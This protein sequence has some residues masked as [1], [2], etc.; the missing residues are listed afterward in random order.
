MN[1]FLIELKQFFL[2]KK[3]LTIL[4]AVCLVAGFLGLSE[5]NQRPIERIDVS[6]MMARYESRQYF[7]DHFENTPGTDGGELM[8]YDWFTQWNPVEKERIEAAKNHDWQQY[9]AASAQWYR[10]GLQYTGG[11]MVPMP[12]EYYTFGNLYPAYDF[13]YHYSYTE[14][15]LTAFAKEQPTKAALEEK[16][17]LQ[18]FLKVMNGWLPFFLI[19]ATTFSLTDLLLKDRHHRSLVAGYP[20]SVTRILLAKTAVALCGAVTVFGL[21][22]LTIVG[23]NLDQ[24]I[25]SLAYP[26]PVLRLT[27]DVTRPIVGFENFDIRSIGNLLGQEFLLYMLI[28]LVIIRLSWLVALWWK[29]EGLILLLTAGAILAGPL[30]ERRW[31]SI[32]IDRSNDPTLYFGLGQIVTGYRRFFYG[33]ANFTFFKG[34]LLFGGI[35][36]VLELILWWWTHRRRFQLLA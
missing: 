19:L 5:K 15:L 4:L 20:L 27:A 29:Q 36:L 8:L 10:Y 30:R 33:S 3:T 21:A 34:C 32:I 17:G 25:G 35:W 22:L 28:S 31:Y 12:P 14:A 18:I 1:Y 23:V 11:Q 6:E 16:T 2:H 9:A 26:V 7:L 24:G 13:Y